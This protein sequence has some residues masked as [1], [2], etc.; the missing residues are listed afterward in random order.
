M[1]ISKISY[2]YTSI[3]FREREREREKRI[4]LKR[5]FIQCELCG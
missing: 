3:Y 4:L 2:K 5:V 1:F